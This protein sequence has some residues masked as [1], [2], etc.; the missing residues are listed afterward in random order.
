MQHITKPILHCAL[1]VLMF[2]ACSKHADDNQTSSNRN[3]GLPSLSQGNQLIIDQIQ[4]KHV[5]LS[6]WSK[7]G[8][9]FQ[10]LTVG[11]SREAVYTLLG[12]PDLFPQDKTHSIQYNPDGDFNGGTNGPDWSLRIHF[13]N[14]EVTKVDFTKSIFGPPPSALTRPAGR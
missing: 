5:D 10:S 1:F 6:R 3:A 11:M 7:I 14:D 2:T 4:A 9:L 8:H 13:V 12:Q